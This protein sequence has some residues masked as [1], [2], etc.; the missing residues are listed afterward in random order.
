MTFAP[1]C[2]RAAASKSKPAA[3]QFSAAK[4]VSLAAI[5]SSSICTASSPRTA[6]QT[7]AVRH[8]LPADGSS[9]SSFAAASS[10]FAAV[11]GA[12]RQLTRLVA[13]SPI[14]FSRSMRR[15]VPRGRAHSKT[16]LIGDVP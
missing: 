3:G 13:G 9:V 6:G 4:I 16:I 5:N 11:N 12:G 2:A 7:W 15:F 14:S 1:S 10:C 8:F